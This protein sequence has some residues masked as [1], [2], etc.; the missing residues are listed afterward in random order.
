MDN[1]HFQLFFFSYYN[2]DVH[3]PKNVR[4]FYH[5][6]LYPQTYSKTALHG[7]TGERYL[8]RKPKGVFQTTYYTCCSSKSCDKFSCKTVHTRITGSHFLIRCLDRECLKINIIKYQAT[9]VSATHMT[10]CLVLKKPLYDTFVNY[11]AQF[12]DNT[13]DFRQTIH[14]NWYQTQHHTGNYSGKGESDR[15]TSPVSLPVGFIPYDANYTPAVSTWCCEAFYLAVTPKYTCDTLHFWWNTWTTITRVLNQY[16]HSVWV[17][18][19][20]SQS[21]AKESKCWLIVA[22]PDDFRSCR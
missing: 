4:S 9:N 12:P 11:F 1:F 19:P 15:L 2:P 6:F 3:Y 5:P 20:T 14:C 7:E 18:V 10:K 8:S 13:L 22:L 21:K 16:S 17:L